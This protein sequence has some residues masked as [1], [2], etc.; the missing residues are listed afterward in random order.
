LSMPRCGLQPAVLRG[1]RQGRGGP[2]KLAAWDEQ[3]HAPAGACRLPIVPP[4]L[5]RREPEERRRR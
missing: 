4:D 1:L 2:D 3:R 5:D